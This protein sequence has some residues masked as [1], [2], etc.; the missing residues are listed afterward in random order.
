MAT[1][2][3]VFNFKMEITGLQGREALEL[4]DQLQHQEH[5]PT[6]QK[7]GQEAVPGQQEDLEEQEGVKIINL[8]DGHGANR[9][10]IVMARETFPDDVFSN[11]VEFEAV[12]F[13]DLYKMVLPNGSNYYWL[14]P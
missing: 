13:E 2:R 9:H 6:L 10:P 4:E 14:I 11:A 7:Q 8:D 3:D 5:E 1:R 12:N